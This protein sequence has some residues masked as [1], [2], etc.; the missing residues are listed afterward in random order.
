MSKLIAALIVITAVLTLSFAQADQPPVQFPFNGGTTDLPWEVVKED[1]GIS[2]RISGSG[3]VSVEALVA[4]LCT[5][6]NKVFSF[7]P[8]A[9]RETRRTV[10]YVAP[11]KGIVI[12]NDEMAE[13]T[14]D[15][16]SAIE[17]TIVGLKG[18]KGRV[19]NIKEAYADAAY[20]GLEELAGMDGADW[21]TVMI[22]LNHTDPKY[23][24]RSIGSLHRNTGSTLTVSLPDGLM[25][26]AKVR[27]L[28]DM[29]KLVADI[30]RPGTGD[31]SDIVRTYDLPASLKSNAARTL[32]DSLFKSDSTQVKNMET[33][34]QV[35]RTS[36]ER[37]SVG[38]TPN[39]SRIVVR[40]T[41]ADHELVK[42]AIEAAR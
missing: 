2:W 29:A 23:V 4:G 21:A 11:N 17:L 36:R 16:L 7:S 33:G 24:E 25:L 9:A 12:K 26:T 39:S 1:N 38:L 30:D 32:I 40:A 34:V 8:Y 15:L 19:V 42:Q 18:S 13:F 35:F 6:Q 14:S 22:R 5:A 3:N 37:V 31:H 28:R 27:R 10:P 41:P 20:V